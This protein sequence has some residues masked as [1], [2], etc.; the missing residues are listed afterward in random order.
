MKI[1]ALIPFWSGYKPLKS[2]LSS[3]PLV[4]VGGK[5]LINRSIEVLNS[6]ELVESTI[7]FTSNTEISNHI[8]DSAKYQILH[9]DARLNTDKTSTEDII[10]EFLMSS[11]TDIVI[12][13][14]PKSPFVRA[15]TIQD[16]IEKVSVGGFDSAFVATQLFHS[17]KRQAWY[18]GKPLNYLIDTD[19]IIL[20][21]LEPVLVESCS[22]YIFTR[23]LFEKNHK[24][25][26]ENPY[27]KEVGHFEGFEV[28]NK[29]DLIMA[30]LMINAGLDKDFE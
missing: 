16:C 28:N 3:K 15:E 30:E 13:I 4:K 14:Q 27:I 5:S 22:I 20:H 6:I 9:R 8:D 21:E 12:L 17:I 2:S 7:V 26:S 1:T 25:I 10:N 18:Q 24:F 23:E 29:D 19:S 11:D